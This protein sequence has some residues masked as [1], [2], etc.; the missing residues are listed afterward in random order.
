MSHLES[1]MNAL[2]SI[3]DSTNKAVKVSNDAKYKRDML[4]LEMEREQVKLDR[5][6]L[7]DKFQ[8]TQKALT[9]RMKSYFSEQAQNPD[10]SSYQD[11]WDKEY[12]SLMT[13][14]NIKSL[15]GLNDEEAQRFID[16]R[17]NQIK[18]AGDNVVAVNKSASAR[19]YL[20]TSYNAFAD[21]EA[22]NGLPLDKS[23][24]RLEQKYESLGGRAIDI[25][26]KSNPMSE[27]NRYN[28]AI[29]KT[30][31]SGK[32]LMERAVSDPE[33]SFDDALN[34][35]DR[36]Y[37]KNMAW[38]GASEDAVNNAIYTNKDVLRKQ[39]IEYYQ[40]QNSINYQRAVSKTEKASTLF[41][42][43]KTDGVSVDEN[44]FEKM[45]LKSLDTNSKN[46]NQVYLDSM[47]AVRKYNESL[48]PKE[49]KEKEEDKLTPLLLERS[50]KGENIED[51]D[52]LLE[53]AGI[54]KD[55]DN[56]YE[57]LEKAM[58]YESKI[59][60][61]EESR[62]KAVYA[63]SEN[64]IK[65]M[66]ASGEYYG[67]SVAYGH[68]GIISD[69]DLASG[70]INLSNSIASGL[71]SLSA[72]SDIEVPAVQTGYSAIVEDIAE[73]YGMTDPDEKRILASYVNNAALEMNVAEM[74]SSSSSSGSSGTSWTGADAMLYS[75]IL[76]TN[77]YSS[78][79]IRKMY[80]W[81]D[82]NGMLSSDFKSKFTSSY[83]G[84]D[85]S[86]RDSVWMSRAKTD[87]DSFKQQLAVNTNNDTASRLMFMADGNG[88]LIQQ[89]EQWEMAHPNAIEADRNKFIDDMIVAV[90]SQDASE[91]IQKIVDDT[92]RYASGRTD[93]S[94]IDSMMS[95]EQAY[96]LTNGT[97]SYLLN[98][99][100]VTM[101][102]E[103]LY[104]DSADK[105]S[106]DS[107]YNDILYS[108][109][110][111]RFKTV[112]D[113]N[114][115]DSL[116][117]AEKQMYSN[118]TYINAAYA[119]MDVSMFKKAETVAKGAGGQYGISNKTGRNLQELH[120]SGVGNAV[121]DE[122]GF[123]YIAEGDDSIGIYYLDPNSEMYSR[124]RGSGN[125][126]VYPTDLK[127]GGTYSLTRAVQKEITTTDAGQWNKY[128]EGYNK[129]F[130]KNNGKK[131]GTPAPEA[132]SLEYYGKGGYS[133]EN[134]MKNS[135]QEEKSTE[136]GRVSYKYLTTEKKSTEYMARDPEL[137]SILERLYQ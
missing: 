17:G 58:S 49:T 136:D 13:V 96:K 97:Y 65:S 2:S 24:K 63:T 55:S 99:D 111:G 125:A 112:S 81:Y 78:A 34:E 128:A 40:Q 110:N 57:A 37:D 30:N 107:L 47:L 103:K 127:A 8:T 79:D 91:Q 6:V 83:F 82:M 94:P 29:G 85:G 15:G 51:F 101:A 38:V 89:L 133:K 4:K 105:Y 35:F 68:S 56:Y 1:A 53:E 20:A 3:A 69:E 126:S 32:Q 122:Q 11:G 42:Q 45:L 28:L 54:N 135:E 90:S 100:A 60:S 74:Q 130:V 129:E 52:A 66:I 61:G 80:D 123:V 64:D 46:D 109:S 7:S 93:T 116:S 31:Y 119:V 41:S 120:V 113:M 12:G 75:C 118:L 22:V 62:A 23:Q 124:V 36:L 73:R 50:A 59:R 5:A 10:Y 84:D 115:S 134:Y 14:D 71:W 108:V 98:T 26:G 70:N 87:Y 106:K 25:S 48:L 44:T 137:Y 76:D 27:S 121:L 21:M 117:A 132:G 9:E 95:I 39:M 67:D 19:T 88:K 131:K 114:K 102:K 16:E 18:L 43:A 33:Y 104:S 77:T 92:F 72:G 86:K